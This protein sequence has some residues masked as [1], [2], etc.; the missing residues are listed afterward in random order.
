M[1][2]ALS[3]ATRHN[4]DIGFYNVVYTNEYKYS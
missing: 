2:F 1:G 3:N 4:F